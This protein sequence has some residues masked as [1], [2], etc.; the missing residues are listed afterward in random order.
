MTVSAQ[1]KILIGLI[2]DLPEEKL[3]QAIDTLKLGL[4]EPDEDEP[5]LTEDEIRGLEIAKREIA[6][7]KIIPFDEVLKELW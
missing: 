6:E 5:P 1:R 2:N 4:L 3:Q 7:G